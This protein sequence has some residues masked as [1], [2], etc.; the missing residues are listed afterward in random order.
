MTLD[1]PFIWAFV[2]AFAVGFSGPIVAAIIGCLVGGSVLL[3]PAIVLGYA[4]KAAEKED[5]ARG[6]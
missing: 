2:I 5:Q 6:L 4:V 1:L 3:A